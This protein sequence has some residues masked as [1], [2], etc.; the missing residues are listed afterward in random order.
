MRL[1]RAILFS[2]LFVLPV[3]FA[4]SVARAAPIPLT[5]SSKVLTAKP[6]IFHSPKGFQ[7]NAGDSGWV[8]ASLSGQHPY[9]VTTYKSETLRNGY[10]AALTVRVD[11][12]QE[13]LDLDDYTKKWMK[14]YPRLGF[15]ILTSKK[16][17]IGETVG[18]LLDLVNR[19]NQIQ[20]RQVLFVKG[21]TA[22]NLTCR[23]H[24]QN[25]DATLKSC[26][27]IIRT[28]KW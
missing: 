2:S 21:K 10:Q 15:E 25:I 27:E 16:V 20:L 19:D 8:Q 24:A 23:D 22:V 6:G 9:I 12:M 1:A 3:T 13:A 26:N 5:T 28:F 18:F 7:L 14:D 17:R 11:D 4:L